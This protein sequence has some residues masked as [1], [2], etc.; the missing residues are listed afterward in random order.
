VTVLVQANLHHKVLN[1]VHLPSFQL[2]DNF[3]NSL[4]SC[5]RGEGFGIG[6]CRTVVEDTVLVGYSRDLQCLVVH[7]YPLSI[8]LF[9]VNNKIIVVGTE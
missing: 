4:I 2:V 3:G 8:V 7:M 9:G 1:P 6:L 5:V